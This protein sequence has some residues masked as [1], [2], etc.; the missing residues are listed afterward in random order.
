M[1]NTF[2]ETFMLIEFA[3]AKGEGYAINSTYAHLIAVCIVYVL[4]I[5]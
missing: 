3:M 1:A 4:G 5:E 2:K